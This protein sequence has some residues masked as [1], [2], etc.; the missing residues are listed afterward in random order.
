M[1]E[2]MARKK[3]EEI[4]KL[5]KKEVAILKDVAEDRCPACGTPTSQIEFFNEMIIKTFGWIECTVCGNVYCPKSILKQKK[6]LA[7]SGIVPA[8]Q[9][10]NGTPFQCP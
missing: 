2:E 5:E 3:Q 9:S 6:V 4:A 8:L 7:R 1:S 10:P